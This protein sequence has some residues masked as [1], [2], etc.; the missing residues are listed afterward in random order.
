MDI[1]FYKYQGT[2]NDF[3]IVDNRDETFKKE[4]DI[5][6]NM[7][8]RR[9]GVGAD[10]LI[11]LENDDEVD[12]RM[13]YYNADGHESTMCGNGGRCIVA[14]AKMLG[15]IDKHTTFRAIDG[16]HKA[17]IIEDVVSLELHVKAQPLRD[18]NG[19][20]IHTGSPHLVVPVSDPEQ[21][22]VE[23]E[24]RTL[25]YDP[26]YQTT[27]GVNV[28]FMSAPIENSKIYVRTYERGVEAETLSCGTGVTAA[29]LV[30]SEIYGIN[31]S[32]TVVTK[33][34]TL[35]VG[36]SK[37]GSTFEHVSLTGEAKFV[38]EGKYWIM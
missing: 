1:K 30:A 2:G 27:G 37:K 5:I 13:V 6:A 12:F 22:S 14:F 33:G 11:L 19:F 20:F 16:L 4:K 9:F 28:N 15:L 35:R 23:S 32:V 34:G 31:E 25:R 26:C 10:G 18:T 36:F 29:A 24:G 7:C 17:W 21:I 3:I 38:F 8:H